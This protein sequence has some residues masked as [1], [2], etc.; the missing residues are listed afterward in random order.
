MTTSPQQYNP[1]ER[2]EAEDVQIQN[3]LDSAAPEQLSG[4]ISDLIALAE[5]RSNGPTETTKD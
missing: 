2:T 3:A 5:S 1:W 4:F